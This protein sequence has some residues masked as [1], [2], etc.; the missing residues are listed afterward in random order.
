ML[1]EFL[2]SGRF[3]LYLVAWSLTSWIDTVTS[4]ISFNPFS[5][6]TFCASDNVYKERNLAWLSMLYSLDIMIYYKRLKLLIQSLIGWIK[7]QNLSSFVCLV[8][9]QL[10]LLSIYQSQESICFSQGSLYLEYH[11]FAPLFLLVSAL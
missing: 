6:N 7:L 10:F 3:I 2:L 8:F 9:S 4:S 5:L 1:N 11:E